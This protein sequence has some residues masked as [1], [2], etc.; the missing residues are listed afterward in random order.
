M[1]PRQAARQA[2]IQVLQHGRNL[3]DAL[4]PLLARIANGKDRALSQALAYGVLR[5]Y[6]KL[7]AILQQLLQKPLRGKDHDVHITLLLGLYQLEFMRIPDHAA[8]AETVRLGKSLKKSWAGGLINGVL[9]NFLRRRD[10]VMQQIEADAV[11]Q[12]AHPRWLLIRLQQDW[13]QHWQ[14]VVEANNAPPPMTLRV[15]LQQQARQQY[16]E[17][18]QQQDIDATPVAAVE[19]ALTLA[20]A[21]EV[22]DLPGFASGAV[23]VQ[24][25]AAQLAAPLLDPQ[26]GER[27]LDA[28]AAP[29]GK[30]L[31]LLEY[32][33]HIAQ[34][35]ALDISATRLARIQQNLQRAAMMTPQGRIT[36][37]EG[38]AAR[39]ADWWDGK[40]FDRILLD[41]PCS[42]SGVIRRHPDIKV[43]RRD[44][45]LDSLVDLQQ[46]ILLAL[47]P[48]LKPG[49]I[50]LYATCSTLR[51]ENT[52]QLER[53]LATQADASLSPLPHAWGHA[54]PAGRQ[55]LPGE[56]GMDGFF[57]ARISKATPA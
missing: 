52:Q 16:L 4:E 28:C 3:P 54:M 5:Q 42:A 57:Y 30:T 17:Q 6:F 9:R 22:N 2:L 10:A 26:P 50:L 44:T 36:L 45:D 29:G 31:H 56:D 35:V 41:A 47:W 15:N 55:I 37:Q 11:A 13:P 33:P 48:L 12:S 43:L 53:F 20:Q 25:A 23:S 21:R 24:D 32:Q 34:L 7:E 49:G 39:P 18:L 38:D 14:A 27:I 51:Q 46:Q 40:A 8:V 19:S 1:N